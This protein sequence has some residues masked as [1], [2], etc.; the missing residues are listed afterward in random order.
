MVL[1]GNRQLVVSSKR[2]HASLFAIST[3]ALTALTVSVLSQTAQAQTIAAPYNSSYNILLN[4]T[5][6]GVPVSYGGVTFLDNDTL[7][8]G[9]NANGG[10]GAIYQ[11]DVTRDSGGHITGFNSS[12]SVFATAPNI[13][14]G[15]TFGPGGVLFATTFSNNNLLQYKPGSTTP[16]RTISLPGFLNSTGTIGIVPAGMPGAGNFYIVSYS[17][18]TWGQ[19]TLTPDGNGTYDVSVAN[20][21]VVTAT[22]PEGIVYVR[23]GNPNFPSSAVLVSEYGQDR[24]SAYQ[25]DANGLPVVATRTDFITGLSGAEGGTVDPLT[26]DFIFSTFGTGSSLVV[27][28]GFTAQVSGPEPGTFAFVGLGLLGAVRTALIRRR[29]R[30]AA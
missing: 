25:V 30:P 3:L 28:G 1:K 6:P 29:R 4:A 8:I 7:L 14:G 10:T 11:I 26:G 19:A 18:G 15:L 21:G 23:A 27:V 17:N 13:D 5:V 9:G 16:D 20:T 22:G 2:R 24:V 12:A